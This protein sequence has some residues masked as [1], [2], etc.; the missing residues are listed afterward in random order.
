MSFLSDIVGGISDFFSPVTSVI[1]DVVGGIGK[2]AGAAQ[3][4]VNSATSAYAA[5][6]AFRG[7]QETNQA[8]IAQAQANRDFQERMSNSAYQRA[9]ADMEKAGL[10]PMLAYSQGGASTPSGSQ[11]APL[12]SARVA[13]VNSAVSTQQALANVDLTQQ[14]AMTERFRR[15]QLDAQA[16]RDKAAGIEHAA[17]ASLKEAQR[18]TELKRPAQVTEDTNRIAQQVS[19]LISQK[20]LTDEEVKQVIQATANAIKTGKQIDANTSNTQLNTQLR[21]LEM[22][23]FF[24]RNEAASTWWGIVGSKFRALFG[25]GG[26][27]SG[28]SSA[29]GAARLIK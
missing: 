16:D 18:D 14:Q 13:A 10:N 4:F 27:E 28:V 19:L 26:I 29:A 25:S 11:A 20:K 1:G 3:P 5:D 6:Q 23:E 7:V 9:T 12:Q 17:G 22:P 2:L 21:M 24:N 8:N 15:D